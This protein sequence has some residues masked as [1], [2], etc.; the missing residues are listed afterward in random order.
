MGADGSKVGTLASVLV[1]SESFDPKAI[2]VRDET[3]LVGR[4]VADEK[5]LVT[6]EVVI[7]IAS[8]TSATHDRVQLS[9]P[10]SD[11]RHEPPYFSYRYKPMTPGQVALEEMQVL[12]GGLGLPPVD[13]IADKP[14]TQIEIDR[15]ENVM[16]GKTGHKLGHVHDVLYDHGELLAIVIRPDGLFK[17]DVVLPIRFISRGDDMALFADLSESD[18]ANL[19]PYDRD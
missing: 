7:P 4:L 13:Q 3:S 18:L 17:H 6:D 2:V 10:S 19:K 12:G 8:V 15:D 5:Y 11:V 14:S 16:L 1:E 9:M